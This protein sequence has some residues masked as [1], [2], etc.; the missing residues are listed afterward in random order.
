MTLTI[1]PPEKFKGRVS[2][3]GDKSISHRAAIIGAL[4]RGTTRIKGYANSQDCRSTLNCLRALGVNIGLDS[5]VLTI[6]GREMK[7]CPPR[8]DL[9]AGN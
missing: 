5:D 9:D 8:G 1:S 7:L 2:L 4:A 6:E 3:P